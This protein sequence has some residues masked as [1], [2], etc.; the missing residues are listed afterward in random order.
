MTTR[1]VDWLERQNI[2]NK[3]AVTDAVGAPAQ[4]YAEWISGKRKPSPAQV[5]KLAAL[6]GTTTDHLYHLL[7]RIPPDIEQGLRRATPDVFR[8]VRIYL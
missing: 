1:F 5:E 7:G 6:F 4:H 2:D 8:A 3:K